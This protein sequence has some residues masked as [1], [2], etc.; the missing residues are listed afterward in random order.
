MLKGKQSHTVGG[1]S[2]PAPHL[3]DTPLSARRCSPKLHVIPT[4][5][6]YLCLA[7]KQTKNGNG[8]SAFWSI[9]KIHRSVPVQVSAPSLSHSFEL[10][11]LRFFLYVQGKCL[12]VCWHAGACRP[13]ITCDSFR[14]VLMSRWKKEQQQIQWTR[15]FLKVMQACWRTH[16]QNRKSK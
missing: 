13:G 2:F 10:L 8:I 9:L 5:I 11:E 12:S 14:W 16:R 15:G 4:L 7:H 3:H 1:T 6:A